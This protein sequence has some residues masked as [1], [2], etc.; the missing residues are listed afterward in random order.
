MEFVGIMCKCQ[1]MQMYLFL[2]IS[3]K[4]KMTHNNLTRGSNLHKLKIKPHTKS[5]FGIP[6]CS[7]VAMPIMHPAL[8]V[9]I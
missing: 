9:D 4:I 3:M 2:K 1:M 6:L 5:K 8:L 7:M